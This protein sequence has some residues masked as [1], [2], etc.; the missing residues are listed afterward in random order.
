MYFSNDVFGCNL[1]NVNPL[2]CLSI[3]NQE[4]NVSPE[5]VNV[6][7]YEPL[8]FFSFTIKRSKH[9]GSCNNPYAKLCAPDVVKNLK[10]LIECQELM[11]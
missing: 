8:F 1:S 11:K 3:N 2:K 9:S 4:C 7:S 5:I 6:N 10:F